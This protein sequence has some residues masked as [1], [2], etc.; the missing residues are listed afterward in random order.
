MLFPDEPDLLEGTE[1]IFFD[2]H[3]SEY[4][5]RFCERLGSEHALWYVRSCDGRAPYCSY[6]VLSWDAVHKNS[7][8]LEK[9]K[10]PGCEPGA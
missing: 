3:G 5:L 6:I 2:Q 8:I 4:D 1:L 10:T 7:M 9:R